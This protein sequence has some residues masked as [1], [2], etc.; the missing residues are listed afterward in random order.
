M[1]I[2]L[3][4]ENFDGRIL[5]ALRRR[6]PALDVLT[7]HEAGLRNTDDRTILEWAATQGRVLLTHDVSTMTRFVGERIRCGENCPGCVI[8]RRTATLGE[9]VEDLVLLIEGAEADE[10]VN[11]I[12][13]I[14]WTDSR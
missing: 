7:V 13:F 9:M 8:V 2:F 6:L 1:P 14:P 4:D 5:R 3:A 12:W 11:R 10:W